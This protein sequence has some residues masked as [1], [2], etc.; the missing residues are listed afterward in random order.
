MDATL[1][2]EAPPR[3]GAMARIVRWLGTFNV[4]YGVLGLVSAGILRFAMPQEFN[5]MSDGAMLASAAA[6]VSA[7]VQGLLLHRYG[8]GFLHAARRTIRSALGR[9]PST[10]P[11]SEQ[12]ERP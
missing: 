11:G 1:S 4:G 8:P 10:R 2:N 7:I 12:E 3:R 9:P 6:S 5:P